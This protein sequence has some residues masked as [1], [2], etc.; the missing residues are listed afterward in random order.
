MR[1]FMLLGT[2]CAAAVLTA[3]PASAGCNINL[4]VTNTGHGPLQIDLER[5]ASKIKLG[6]WA[7]YKGRITGVDNSQKTLLI[8]AGDV[9][10]G[11]LQTDFDCS[12][13]R[14][15][16]WALACGELDRTGAFVP[17]VEWED[18]SPSDD[19]W[20]EN[21]SVAIEKSRCLADY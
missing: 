10:A 2:L 11:T 3:P 15:F 6:V 4:R 19:G 5:S 13:K 7:N 17:A 21:R 8:E 9:F 14:R 16:R 18:Y 20:T 12:T 1:H